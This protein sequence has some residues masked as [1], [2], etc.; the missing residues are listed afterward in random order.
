M[1][2]KLLT[3]EGTK[4]PLTKAFPNGVL[5]KN[6]LAKYGLPKL[7]G[8]FAFAMFM[9]NAAVSDGP[10]LL[11]KNIQLR[12][13]DWSIDHALL[14]FLGE[15]HSAGVQKRQRRSIGRS[16]PYLYGQ[17]LQGGTLVVVRHYSPR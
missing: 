17:T 7:S 12:I 1:S 2:T 8:S 11:L 16:P 4:Y 6:I 10:S 14:S 15:R 5:D 13:L 9:A 3:A